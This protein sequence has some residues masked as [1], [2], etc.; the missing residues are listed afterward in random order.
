[1]EITNTIDPASFDCLPPVRLS[2]EQ[3]ERQVEWR[4]DALDT[5]F[6]KGGMSNTEYNAALARLDAWAAGERRSAGRGA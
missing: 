2:E 4:T 1:M 5:R 3:I 6:L